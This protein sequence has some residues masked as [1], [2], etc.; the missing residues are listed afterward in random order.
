MW[1]DPQK[2]LF[3]V[4]KLT[5]RVNP[6]R[7]AIYE[8]A[9]RATTKWSIRCGSRC[10]TPSAAEALGNFPADIH[11]APLYSQTVCVKTNAG[12]G[13]EKRTPEATP[14]ACSGTEARANHPRARDL[15]RLSAREIVRLINREDA[16]VARAVER[17]LPAVARAAEAIAAAIGRGGRLIYVGAGTSGRLAMLDASE[18]PPTFG[19]SPQAGAR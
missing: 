1:I 12:P 16:Q 7:E 10:T 11:V 9:R 2:Q 17:E 4:L 18:L 19:V 15:D 5:N 3:V 13:R 14:A 6:S 8:V